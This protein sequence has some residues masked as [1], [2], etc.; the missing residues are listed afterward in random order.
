MDAHPAANE[1][2]PE[3]IS[4]RGEAIAWACALLVGGAWLALLLGGK[5][6]NLLV[7]ILAIPLFLAAMSISLGNWVDRRTRL[8]LDAEGVA[9]Q[10]GLRD[11]RMAWAEI[12]QVRVF[13]AQWSQKIQVIGESGHFSFHTLGE[14]KFGRQ[15]KGR[16]GFAAGETILK[17]IV[18]NGHLREMRPTGQAQQQSGYYYARD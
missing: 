16:V 18:E 3:L 1:F 9:F 7:L 13:P 10:N 14:V 15:V 2:R 11:V 8:R 4:R 6:A 12:Q 5:G 17:R